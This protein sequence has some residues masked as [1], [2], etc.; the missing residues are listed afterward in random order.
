MRFQRSPTSAR[1]ATFAFVAMSYPSFTPNQRRVRYAR[2]RAFA[3]VLRGVPCCSS[4][5]RVEAAK[6][7]LRR[8]WQRKVSPSGA[9][10]AARFVLRAAAQ[11]R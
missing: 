7:V 3:Q 6:A 4:G 8:W 11:R 9:R 1:A 10:S 2:A 5:A